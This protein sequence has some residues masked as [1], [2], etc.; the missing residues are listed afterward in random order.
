MAILINSGYSVHC[1]HCGRPSGATKG[2]RPVIPVGWYWTGRSLRFGRDDTKSPTVSALWCPKTPPNYRIL[3]RVN[4]TEGELRKLRE[5]SR[6]KK[7][8][9]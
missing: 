1:E 4:P 7:A 2:R 6:A 9:G 3:N 8:K 5:E